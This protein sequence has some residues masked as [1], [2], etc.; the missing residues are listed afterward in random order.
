MTDGDLDPFN[1][2]LE[3]AILQASTSA[4]NTALGQNYYVDTIRNMDTDRLIRVTHP[5]AL[6]G[7]VYIL[8]TAEIVPESVARTLTR[9]YGDPAKMKALEHV[10]DEPAEEPG[11]APKKPT[12]DDFRVG[13]KYRV[14]YL[15]DGLR[16][17]REAVMVYLGL[18]LTGLSFDARPRWGTQV[19]PL[20]RI[21]EAEEVPLDT[22]IYLGRRVKPAS[23]ARTSDRPLG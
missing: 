20:D 7:E 1:G 6:D 5:T 16:M 11:E 2:R 12:A 23:L 17:R 10:F 3:R 21:T 19:L 15:I 14:R 13:T 8:V 18:G 22:E 4:V 9:Q